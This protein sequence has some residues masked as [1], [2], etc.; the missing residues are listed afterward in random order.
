[1]KVNALLELR[2]N[3]SEI[4]LLERVFFVLWTR[5]LVNQFPKNCQ[6]NKAETGVIAE[7]ISDY[8]STL[9][10]TLSSIYTFS[11]GAIDDSFF[12]KRH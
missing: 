10:D 2:M 4:N 11:L 1:M 6:L 9:Q 5:E 8:I 7:S 3:T 12:T